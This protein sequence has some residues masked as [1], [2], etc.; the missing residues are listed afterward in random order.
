MDAPATY[1]QVGFI[2]ISVPNALLIGGMILLFIVA[3]LAPFPGHGRDLEG[4][5]HERD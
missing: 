5:D 1:I 3:L 2:L 4:D